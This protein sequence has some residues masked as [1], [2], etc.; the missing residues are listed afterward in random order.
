M[1]MICW[2]YMEEHN[3][4]I[5]LAQL[6]QKMDE[7]FSSMRQEFGGKLEAVN[8]RMDKGFSSMREEFNGKLETMNSRMDAGFEFLGKEIGEVRQESQANYNRLKLEVTETRNELNSRVDG[9]HNRMVTL[10]RGALTEK[11]KT[12]LMAMVRAYDARLMA[13]ALGTAGEDGDV[14]TLTRE[15]YDIITTKLHIPNRYELL[16]AA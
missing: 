10:E 9:L 4:D 13:E 6:A 14:I 8:D 5:T 11:D 2:R 3:Q 16:Q 15:E 7:G 12:D 1:E